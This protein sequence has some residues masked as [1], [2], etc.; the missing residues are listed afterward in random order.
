MEVL[1]LFPSIALDLVSK[2]VPGSLLLML[3]INSSISITEVISIHLDNI[4]FDGDNLL[5]YQFTLA[6]TAAYILGVLIALLANILDSFLI[7]KCWYSMI[8]ESTDKYIY[9][10]DV[11]DNFQNIL[12]SSRNF[13]RFIDHS[14]SLISIGR[15]SSAITIE[16]YRTAYRFF[17]GLSLTSFLSLFAAN[18]DFGWY[19]V[20]TMFFATLVAL[21]SSHRYLCKSIQYY[22]FE[23]RETN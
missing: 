19:I 6:I 1:K 7:T 4:S 2:I 15:L 14:R 12:S 9:S 10:L 22:S 23:I 3:L 16:K 11:P 20:V 5:W 13:E 21:Y 8:R 18:V 17:F